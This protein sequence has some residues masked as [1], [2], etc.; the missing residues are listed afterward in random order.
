MRLDNDQNLKKAKYF[1]D[2]D[3]KEGDKSLESFK[4]ALMDQKVNQKEIKVM[5]GEKI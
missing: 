4:Q 5:A 2:E 3:Q 1:V